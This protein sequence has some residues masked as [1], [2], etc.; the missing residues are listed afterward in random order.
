MVLPELIVQLRLL[1]L[2]ITLLLCELELHARNDTSRKD[3]HRTE[4][5]SIQDSLYISSLEELKMNYIIVST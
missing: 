4:Q 3:A 5:K 2:T 1:S